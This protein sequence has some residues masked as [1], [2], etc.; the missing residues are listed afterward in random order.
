MEQTRYAFIW[1]SRPVPTCLQCLGKVGVEETRLT[2]QGPTAERFD[3]EL[4]HCGQC[5]CWYGVLGFLE[6]MLDAVGWQSDELEGLRIKGQKMRV[7][8]WL[9]Q[10][11]GVLPWEEMVQLAH[12]LEEPS[13]PPP[14]EDDVRA[15]PRLPET[16]QVGVRVANWI[17][18]EGE[19]PVLAYLALV[20]DGQQAIRHFMLRPGERHD[21][22]ALV[23]LI[24]E[25]AVRPRAPVEPGRPRTI[26]IDDAALAVAL[27]RKLKAL[28]IQVQEAPTPQVDAIL[29]NMMADTREEHLPAYLTGIGRAEVVAF[30]KAARA[31][32]RM[33]PWTSFDGDRY[34]GV[35]YGDA[36]WYYVNVMG[37]AGDEPGLSL[38]TDWLQLCRF[39][40]NTHAWATTHEEMVQP[41]RAAGGIEG[42]TLSPLHMLHPEDAEYIR[43]L[44]IR[45]THQKMYAL[46]H[47]YLPE[48]FGQPS[49]PLAR[50][51]L[52][53]EGLVQVLKARRA[54]YIAS[55]NR[56]VEVD[57]A[58]LI[59]SYPARGMEEMPEAAGGFRLIITA[60]PR[61]EA[62]AENIL[63]AGETIEVDAPGEVLVEEIGWAIRREGGGTFALRG[64]LED[65]F[66][67]WNATLGRGL[68]MP[69]VLH[70][71][72]LTSLSVAFYA[73]A[74]VRYP[75]Q[76]TRLL[77]TPAE[78]RVR[79]QQ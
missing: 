66:F 14:H 15:L 31:F 70:L 2:L 67:L 36:P 72:R 42:M 45:P 55:L 1:V 40:Q 17:V 63:G 22:P 9:D 78:I 71:A 6:D 35:K 12:E 79:L 29:Q 44:K 27:R 43:Q 3:V 13:G 59:F 73:D 76:V 10:R 57:G 48:G 26:L 77:E 25:A 21:A 30:F 7:G 8:I 38:F 37:Q 60:P 16:W 69:R 52:L 62:S 75:L 46:P 11:T 39:V 18:E 41:I 5:G 50:Y 68:P 23:E 65:E 34:L 20:L 19:A 58:P 33:A 56:T 74:F 47:C 24:Y 4:G 64:I 54:E 53:M 32:Y 49:F 28:E 51:R 61:R